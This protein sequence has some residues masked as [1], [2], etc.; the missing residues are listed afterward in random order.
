MTLVG[1]DL[2]SQTQQVAVLDT[3]TG[4][5]FEHELAHDCFW[6][7]GVGGADSRAMGR[8]PTPAR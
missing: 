2:H 6:A 1:C 8:V 7:F 5:I 3:T 4:E